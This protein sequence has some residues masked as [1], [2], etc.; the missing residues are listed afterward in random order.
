MITPPN[1]LPDNT[2]YLTVCGSTSYGCE[3]SNSDMDIYGFCIPTKEIVFPHTAGHIIGFDNYPKF[4]HYQQHHVKD[5]DALGGKGREYDVTVYSIV[6][7]FSL[8]SDNNPNMVDSI[9]TDQDC[10][11]HCSNIGHMVR[12]NRKIF[13]HKGIYHKMRAYAMSQL[14]KMSSKEREGKRKESYDK[15]GWDL[16]FGYHLCRLLCEVQQILETGDLNLRKDREFY[17]A[18]RR[19][20]LTEQEVREWATEKDKYLEQL[21]QKT[22]LPDLPRDKEIKKLLL[23]CLEAHY[24]NLSSVIEK[25]DIAKQTLR[26][27]IKLAEGAL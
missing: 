8:V 6:R 1:W 15:W 5:I 13:L 23:E 7:Y 9:F 16:K 24:G 18:I 22:S 21:Y 2:H 4:E 14:H 10:V 25:P 11:L 12:D 26:E 3:S 17:K 20:D 19:G 27:I